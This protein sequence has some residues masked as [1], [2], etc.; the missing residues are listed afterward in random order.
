MAKEFAPRA[1][2]LVAWMDTVERI[3]TL[4]LE[5]RHVQ[6]TIAA[7]LAFPEL[8]AVFQYEDDY[9][10]GQYTV[11]KDS[12]KGIS[13]PLVYDWSNAFEHVFPRSDFPR[14]LSELWR[15]EFLPAAASIIQVE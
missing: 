7:Q 6:E 1:V 11:R 13:D 8:Y 5:I 12:N 4:I 3:N 15:I 10:W 14:V 9:L 2:A